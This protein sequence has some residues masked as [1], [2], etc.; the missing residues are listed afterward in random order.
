M[1]KKIV[2]G[3]IVTLCML[4]VV[5]S[6]GCGKARPNPER[7]I[8]D[9]WSA[10]RGGDRETAKTYL[11]GGISQSTLDE[12]GSAE[13]WQ[14]QT[15]VT[16]MESLTMQIVSSTVDGDN[17]T[18]SVELVMPDMDV[19]RAALSEAIDSSMSDIT[20]PSQIN[21]DEFGKMLLDKLPAIIESA[22]PKTEELDVTL[23]WENGAWKINSDPFAGIQS[24]L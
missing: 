6:V 18:V 14:S 1:T 9:F 15:F 10:V 16:L 3:F 19:V 21:M 13:V 12:L 22:P 7:T 23:V 4:L 20:D 5:G 11:A 17:A 24:P 2:A 8:N